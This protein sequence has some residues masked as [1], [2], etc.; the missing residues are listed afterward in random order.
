MKTKKQL[1]E[2]YIDSEYPKEKWTEYQR[3]LGKK[4]FLAGYDARDA[5]LSKMPEFDN[6]LATD[7][8][9]ELNRKEQEFNNVNTLTEM[10]KWQFQKCA[11]IIAARDAEIARLQVCADLYDLRTAERNTANEKIR[12]LES[13]V[14]R[15]KARASE[16]SEA[17]KRVLETSNRYYERLTK[18]HHKTKDSLEKL[19]V[20]RDI[21]LKALEEIAV[22]GG[23]DELTDAAKISVARQAIIEGKKLR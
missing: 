14:E 16:M 8:A 4:D 22:S 1:S 10:A 17:D 23:R 2:E 18:E 7:F 3:I 6:Y 5:E 13:E 21:Y 15:W 12:E 19:Q 9:I 11:K 20:E